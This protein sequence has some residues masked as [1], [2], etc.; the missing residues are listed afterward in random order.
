L[1]R[2]QLLYQRPETLNANVEGSA[3]LLGLTKAQFIG[4]AVKQPQL[5]CQELWPK[6]GDGIMR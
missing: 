2:P 3:G 5:F 6:V 1:K 4:V